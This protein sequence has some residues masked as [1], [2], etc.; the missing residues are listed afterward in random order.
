[1]TFFPWDDRYRIGVDRIDLQHEKLVGLLND[2]YEAMHAGEGREALSRVLTGLTRYVQ[3]HFSF[4]EQMMR[5]RGYPGF[6]AHREKH[7]K[8]TRKV[9]EIQEAFEK[10]DIISPVQVSNFLK[11]WL[12]KHIMETDRKFGDFCRIQD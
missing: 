5:E 11:G 6:S 1:M 4:E 8:M 7:E 12:Q 9:M 10:G 2:L 3:T